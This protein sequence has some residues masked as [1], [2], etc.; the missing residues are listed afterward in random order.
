M[1]KETTSF[2]CHIFPTWS[3][4][5]WD[6]NKHPTELSHGRQQTHSKVYVEGQRRRTA[7]M[8]LNKKNKFGVLTIPNFQVYYKWQQYWWK[9]WQIAQW[10]GVESPETDTHEYREM[11]F[12]KRTKAIQWRK[13]SLF[14]K[15]CWKTGHLLAERLILTQTF[16]ENQFK[17]DHRP[18]VNSK[19]I[20]FQKKTD[21][22]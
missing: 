18:K 7:N 4:I 11:I 6:P 9:N 22:I 1:D 20:I 10:N 16:H 2:G 5:Q 15:W 19:I 12:G 14:N 3:Q 8:I 17:M 21:K 13:N